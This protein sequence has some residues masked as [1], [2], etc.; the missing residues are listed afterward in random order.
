MVVKRMASRGNCL[1]GTGSY[2]LP[3][4]ARTPFYWLVQRV[5]GSTERFPRFVSVVIS[6]AQSFA[7]KPPKLQGGR[8]RDAQSKNRRTRERS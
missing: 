5:Q 4:N 1:L 6:I 2:F 7:A 3:Q 8:S